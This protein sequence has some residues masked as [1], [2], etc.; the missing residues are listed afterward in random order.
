MVFG[1]E[2]TEKA[3]GE[4][5]SGSPVILAAKSLKKCPAQL[6]NTISVI[7][8]ALVNGANPLNGLVSIVLLGRAG[9]LIIVAQIGRNKAKLRENETVADA[10][11]VVFCPIL[12][13]I[14]IISS[15]FVYSIPIKRPTISTI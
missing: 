13:C 7:E 15:R 6:P 5:A 10:C 9:T 4:S 8:S 2:Y 11:I 14:F 3:R 1:K 12:H